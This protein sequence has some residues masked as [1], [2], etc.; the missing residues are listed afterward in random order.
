M[1]QQI[2]IIGGMGPQ[3]SIELHRRIIAA[4][5]DQGAVNGDDFPEII[6]ASLPIRDFINAEE[7][8]P[9]AATINRA[10]E[11]FW[12]GGSQRVVMACNTAH[13]LI[14]RLN[15]HAGQ[16]LVSLTDETTNW[17]VAHQFQRI[18]LLASPTTLRSGLY[19]RQLSTAGVQLI[20]P[21]AHEVTELESIIRATIGGQA[22][23]T[24]R[25]RVLVE[26]LRAAGCERVLLGCTELS[27]V[28]GQLAGCLDPLQL[29][30]PRL[31]AS[32][33]AEFSIHN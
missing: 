3:A 21:A 33:P 16:Q 30:V 15:F 26:R 20:L 18:G 5:A 32:V 24:V 17:I 1:N 10:L 31:L 28:A 6:H 29:V 9:A 11:R 22:G 4:A 23:Q 2:L 27:V 7:L 13:I 19:A 14:P 25:L 8:A 12:N